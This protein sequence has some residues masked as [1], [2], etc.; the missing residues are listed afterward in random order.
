MKKKIVH[1]VFF[2]L[3]DPSSKADLDQLIRGVKGLGQI[4]TVQ[5][6]HVGIPAPTAQR[7]VVDNSYSLSELLFFE[8]LEGQQVYQDHPL[9][10]KFIT[11]CSHLWERVAVYDTI[12]V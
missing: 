2:W 10:Q 8:D 3:K 9:H 12:D 1:H 11:E 5:E 7:S 6:I 4:E